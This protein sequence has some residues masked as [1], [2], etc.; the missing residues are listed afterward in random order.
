MCEGEREAKK[1]RERERWGECESRQGDGEGTQ[2]CL[3]SS[4]LRMMCFQ[5]SGSA[6]NCQTSRWKQ[7]V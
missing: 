2:Y 6:D 3:V 4:L 5:P 7:M 1:E